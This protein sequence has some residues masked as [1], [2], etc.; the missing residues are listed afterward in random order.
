MDTKESVVNDGGYGESA[1]GVYAGIIYT[2][3]VFME[4][5]CRVSGVGYR[6]TDCIHSRLK[7]KYSVRCLHS[8]FP[9]SRM[10]FDG[11]RILRA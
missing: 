11:L 4:A 7:V 1:K 10:S 3:T 9:R 8:W 5:C 2:C 6:R